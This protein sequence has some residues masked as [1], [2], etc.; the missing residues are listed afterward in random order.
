MR[1]ASLRRGMG[2][3]LQAAVSHVFY[4]FRADAGPG[5]AAAAASMASGART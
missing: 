4:I 5:P 3:L 2:D 1:P